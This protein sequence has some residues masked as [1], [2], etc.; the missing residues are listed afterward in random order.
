MDSN[1]ILKIQQLHL[2]AL[3]PVIIYPSKYPVLTLLNICHC[4]LT[5]P[6]LHLPVETMLLI[7]CSGSSVDKV[8]AEMQC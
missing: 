7:Q 8:T 1:V 2:C 6:G 5:S 4:L 3:N